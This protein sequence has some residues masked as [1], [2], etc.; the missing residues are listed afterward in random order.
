MKSMIIKSA[1]VIVLCVCVYGTVWAIPTMRL[2]VNSEPAVSGTNCSGCRYVKINKFEIT[3][4][5][6]SQ[7]NV[8]LTPE[9]QGEADSVRV[10][11]NSTASAT[12]RPY[13]IKFDKKQGLFGKT[14]G[15]SWVLLANYYDPT[16]TL[17]AI[18]F[19]LGKKLGL[20]FTNS[21]EFVNLYFI[22]SQGRESYK[23]IYLL[24]EQIQVNAGRVD[25]DPDYGFL[26]EFDYHDAASDEVKFTA[27]NYNDLPTFI[28]SPEIAGCEASPVKDCNINNA[29]VKWVKDSID[30]LTRK[31]SEG[32]FPTNG[33]R[34]MIDLESF[35]KYVL[36]QKLM[37]NFDFNNKVEGIGMT[38]VDMT[39]Q[40]GS[41]YAYKDIGSRLYAGPLW[42]FDL[43]AGVSPNQ[44]GGGC[45]FPSHY[46]M[47]NE[48][49]KP[50]NK[51]YA[52]LWEDPV[53][54]AKLK[55]TWDRHQS[56]FTAIPAFIDSL[57]NALR[58]SVANNTYASSGFGSS[59]L[60]ENTFN[61]QVTNL[62]KWWNDRMTF[63]GQEINKLNINVNNDIEQ[64]GPHPGPKQ[65]STSVTARARFSNGKKVSAVKNG[66][67][68]NVA[69]SASVKIFSLN[70]SV[71][72]S[73]KLTRGQH[74]VRF[75]NLPKG[76]Y[77][78]RV[79]VDGD[80][81]VLRVPVR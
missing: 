77:M 67:A 5:G 51:F 28:K 69:N 78:V 16:F 12:K 30:A 37:D 25:V 70:G 71:I 66:I 18:A 61:T 40:P 59:T 80:K 52:R 63:Y 53:F 43:A 73:Q 68:L 9:P 17:N 35:A 27:A 13:R 11:G 49:I 23:G 10:R 36:I 38:G 55:K 19:R 81:Q 7:H 6:N 72:R 48:P 22:N 64:P 79:S 34:D 62:K 20:E 46:C 39:G 32:G 54:L 58:S 57:A 65:Q 56:D 33:Y 24:T 26:V 41:N 8:T 50:K 31:I 21:S 60:N 2:T 75:G 47:T 45:T 74:S 3:G 14:P 15:K 1:A 42:D 29:R 76:M 44:T 4:A